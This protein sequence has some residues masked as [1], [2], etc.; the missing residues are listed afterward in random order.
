MGPF[1][2]EGLGVECVDHSWVYTLASV[3]KCKP[4]M[5]T[6]SCVLMVKAWVNVS[7]TGEPGVGTTFQGAQK[8]EAV[9]EAALKKRGRRVTSLSFHV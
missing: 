2:E 5:K 1:S 9:Q 7:E 6:L 8:T 4:K 3:E